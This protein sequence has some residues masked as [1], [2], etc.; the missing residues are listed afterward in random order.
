MFDSISGHWINVFPYYSCIQRKKNYK[1]ALADFEFIIS[2]GYNNF[3]ESS[4]YKAAVIN[5]NYLKNYDKAIN[6]YK[7]L[8]NI[9]ND[10]NKKY[11]VQLGIMRSAFMM[12]DFENVNNY[13]N[14]ILNNQ[15]TTDKEKSA[16]HYYIGKVAEAN[17]KYDIALQQLNKVIKE[18]P[19]SN[20]AAESRYLI[21][22]V[23]F[24]RK[25]TDLAKKMI[26]DASSK[27]SAYPYWVAKGLL[28]LSEI[29]IQKNDIFNAKA[30]LEAI[31]E[32]YQEDQDILKEVDQKL[33]A[34]SKQAADKSRLE[35]GTKEGNLKMEN[36]K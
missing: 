7:E 17:K 15:L 24:N 35:V 36:P 1:E 13:G 8:A 30:A 3:Y 26:N 16:A 31:K 32:N 2:K 6:Y 10:E 18:N 4:L 12:N 28:L 29:Y 14:F 23:Y 22:R 27:N 9:V 33:V 34:I 20:L 19:N 21:S 25:E 11:E 5:F